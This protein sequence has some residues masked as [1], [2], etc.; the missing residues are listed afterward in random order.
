MMPLRQAV[1]ETTYFLKIIM[2]KT[3]HQVQQFRPFLDHGAFAKGLS[4]KLRPYMPAPTD[5]L[6]DV[7][8]HKFEMGKCL[9]NRFG[10]G[11]IGN[12]A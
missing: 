10:R 5:T 6:E 1:C 11:E 8:R 9:P 7:A 4:N 2:I 12:S 3:S